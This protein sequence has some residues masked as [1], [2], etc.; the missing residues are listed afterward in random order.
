VR[1]LRRTCGLLTLVLLVS[2]CSAAPPAPPAAQN[3]PAKPAESSAATPA[4]AKP[5]DSGAP[6]P[7][8]AAP[9][10]APAAA[11]PAAGG[12]KVL[13]VA[14]PGDATTMDAN[15]H[16]N[17]PTRNIHLNL[18]GSPVLRDAEGKIQPALAESWSNPDPLTWVFKIRKGVKFHNGNDLT[19]EDLKF[20]LERILDPANKSPRASNWPSVDKIEV[21]DPYT[22]VIHTK[23][24]YPLTLARMSGSFDIV[25]KKYF[26]EVGTEKA[27]QDPVGTGPY[28]FKEWTKNQ[29]VVLEAFDG[30]WGGRPKIDRV[31]FRSI[32]EPSTRLAELLAGTVDIVTDVSA[33]QAA[34]LEGK[35]GV[36]VVNADATRVEFV[37]LDNTREGPLQDVRV[38]QA[39]NYAVDKEGLLKAL[40][41]G[42]G[43]AIGQV[44][45]QPM[46]GYNP[47]VKPYPYDPDKAK[48]LL[49]DAGFANGL[50]IDFECSQSD[51][52]TCEAIA[53]QLGK[54]GVTAKL[55]VYDNTVSA[56]RFNQHQSSPMFFSTWLGAT[57]DAEGT[58]T[59]RIASAGRSAYFSDPDVDK[60]IKAGASTVNEAD[61]LKVYL[62]LMAE[63]KDKAPWIYL[64]Q[65]TD[66]YAVSQRL[67]GWVPRPD[68]YLILRGAQVQ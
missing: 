4:A 37:A 38:R 21:P 19:A 36:K 47:D 65:G 39:L 54:V 20:S 53:L 13:V 34:D 58:L 31:I 67:S 60:E 15:M 3:A 6:K 50:S 46:F 7:T 66:T 61:R 59:P 51:K 5:A 11:Q 10:S 24:P 2:A 18:F 42:H 49:A 14:Q 40:Y 16:N 33:D 56:Q 43:Q 30:Y 44:V 52:D 27:I 25:S 48:Q 28:K 26:E 68:S 1:S 22:F 12:E 57:Q 17:T 55:T 29:Q 23:E 63:L 64:W 9:T 35:S 45:S 32:P 8:A 41:G 62:P